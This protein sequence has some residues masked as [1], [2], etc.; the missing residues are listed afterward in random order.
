MATPTLEVRIRR[1]LGAASAGEPDWLECEDAFGVFY[2][3]RRTRT[4][5][6]ELP[7]DVR[8]AA[9]AMT[10]SYATAEPSAHSA[11]SAQQAVVLMRIGH[12]VIAEDNLGI[13]YQSVVTLESYDAPPPELQML[14]HRKRQVEQQHQQQQLLQQHQ[15]QLPQQQRQ[16]RQ[17]RQERL[18]LQHDRLE[19]WERQ[20]GQKQGLNSHTLPMKVNPSPPSTVHSEPPVPIHSSRGAVVT[21]R[22]AHWAVL[23][24]SQG[25]FYQNM[26]TGETFEDPPAELLRIL[27]QRIGSPD[28]SDSISSKS[29][30]TW[31]DLAAQAQPQYRCPMLSMPSMPCSFW[32]AQTSSE[33]RGESFGQDA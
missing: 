5:A 8:R 25:E 10:S 2:Y 1:D 11:Y 7:P 21:M 29:M 23:R 20:Q 30:P 4:A 32:E 9:L 12:W 27:R 33:L 16:E 17:E 31:H 28:D 6:L 22:I 24:N 13:F 15:Q 26:E 14:L 18:Q 19:K 3:S